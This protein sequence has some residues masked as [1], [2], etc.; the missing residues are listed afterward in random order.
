[1]RAREAGQGDHRD[2]GRLVGCS[3]PAEGTGLTA[4]PG[5]Q[6]KPLDLREKFVKHWDGQ[7]TLMCGWMWHA[8]HQSADSTLHKEN[9]HPE[10]ISL[11]RGRTGSLQ[12]VSLIRIHSGLH[13]IQ[14][15]QLPASLLLHVSY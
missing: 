6:G 7:T 2:S 1:M 5:S 10:M 3:E 14:W 8:A 13:V 4:L 12:W 15:I 9:T 11:V